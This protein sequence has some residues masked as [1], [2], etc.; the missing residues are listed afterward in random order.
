[1]PAHTY[2][3]GLVDRRDGGHRNNLAQQLDTCAQLHHPVAEV[4]AQRQHGTHPAVRLIRTTTSSTGTV[5]GADGLCTATSTARTRA[6]TRQT[7][8]I[9]CASVSI[10]S[11]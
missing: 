5:T 6:S 9:R 1:L 2:R 7:S 8:A 10:R 3:I 11:T 4:G